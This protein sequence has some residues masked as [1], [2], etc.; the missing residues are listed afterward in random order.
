MLTCCDDS[1]LVVDR[2]RDQAKQNTA[3][4]SFYFN[5]SVRKELTATAMLGSMLKQMVNGMEVIPEDISRGLK[6]QLSTISG[7]ELELVDIVKILQLIT[8][9][10]PTIMCIDGLDECGAAQRVKIL[11]SLKQILERSPCMRV[12]MTGRPHVRAEIEERLAGRVISV[13]VCP[14]KDDIITYLRARLAED[15]KPDAMDESLEADILEKIL[16]SLSGM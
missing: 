1:S 9:S 7:Y 12:F 11:D 8:S 3:V 13:S 15:E 5:F 2:L 16:E 14:S 4:T 6:E 10:Q